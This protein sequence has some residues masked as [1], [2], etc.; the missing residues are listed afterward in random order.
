M[1]STLNMLFSATK[2]QHKSRPPVQLYFTD[3]FTNWAG[4]LN[5]LQAVIQQAV[6]FIQQGDVLANGA[7]GSGSVIRVGWTAGAGLAAKLNKRWTAKLE[8]LF[9]DLASNSYALTGASNGLSASLF[10]MGVNYH[11]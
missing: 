1:N 10:R 8:Y 9:V 5:G 4:Q 6:N 2:G 7:V 11:F 3:V